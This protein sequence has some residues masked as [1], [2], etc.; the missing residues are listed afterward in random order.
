MEDPEFKI[1]YE[2]SEAEYQVIRALVAAR[3]EEGM[4][5]KELSEK[6]G[7][8][9]SNISRIE[10]GTSIP[11]VTTLQALAKG[12][13]RTLNIDFLRESSLPKEG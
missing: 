11:N 13:G 12:L 6:S 5:Q 10:N 1:E 9:Q 3:L 4:T 2:A 8:R 7:I